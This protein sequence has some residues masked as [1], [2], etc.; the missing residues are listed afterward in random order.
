[1]RYT[2]KI[3]CDVKLEGWTV[4]QWIN[5]RI[6]IANCLGLTVSDIT[7][8]QTQRG[9]HTYMHIITD[10]PLSPDTINM[11]Q[12]LLGDDHGRVNINSERIKRGIK[13]WNKLYARV[14]YR[15]PKKT[16]KCPVCGYEFP[17]GYKKNKPPACEKCQISYGS[18]ECY[19]CEYY[20]GETA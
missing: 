6:A 3:D 16:V 8:K 2:L 1:M 12:L 17:I 20:A 18:P 4:N 11:Y 10:H 5:T 7:L 19:R 9:F 15:R 13:G 14:S